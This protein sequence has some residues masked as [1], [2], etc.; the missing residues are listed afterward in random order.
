MRFSTTVFLG[1]KTA[2]GLVVPDDVVEALGAGQ[3]PPVTVTVG[4][5]TYRTT[6]ARMGGQFLVPLAAEHRTAA[7]VAAGDEVEVEIELDAAPRTVDVPADLATALDGEPGLRERFDA[8][9]FSHRKEHVRSVE[10]AKAEA[11]RLRR[12]DKVL[13]AL[14]QA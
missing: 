11:T 2:T 5:H 6:V 9:A 13:A 14:R 12:I 3:R 4:A 1:G 8:L 10:D 7:G